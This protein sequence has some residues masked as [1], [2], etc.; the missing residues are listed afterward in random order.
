MENTV[1]F[2]P[3]MSWRSILAGVLVALFSFVTLMA[4]GVA[5]GGVS[6][7]DGASLQ[8][9]GIF[10]GVWVI[11]SSIISLFIAGYFVA[12][13][14]N[15]G[16]FRIGMGQGAVV[17]A[18]FFGVMMW[19]AMG[20]V[21]W[22]AKS[23]GSVLG[24]VAQVGAPAAADAIA[25]SNLNVGNLIEDNLDGVQFK[26]DS[27][28][29]I[30]G[31]ASRLVQGE[32]ESAKNYLARNSSLTRA[33]VDTRIDQAQAQIGAVADKARVTAANALKVSGWSMFAML[34]LGLAAAV[35]G[36]YLGA[37]SNVRDPLTAPVRR[38]RTG[39]AHA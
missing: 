39:V 8:N 13:V 9:A 20:M 33:E 1:A 27:K 18:L 31:V 34:I 22:I 25:N 35:G 17:A 7:T 29:V 11:L 6:L 3:A 26:G 10:S 4:L 5:I 14:S 28:T 19:Q 12:R 37:V 24:S 32:T 36:G 21:G 16:A 15:F 23:T 30:S 2:H 38:T